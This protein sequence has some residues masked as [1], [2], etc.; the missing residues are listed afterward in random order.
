MKLKTLMVKEVIACA[1][2]TN[3]EEAGRLMWDHDC[4]AIPVLDDEGH[5][6]GIV[7]DRDIAMSAVLNHKPLWDISA[8]EVI[9]SREVFTCHANDDIQAALAVMQS[10]HI[11][12]MP[13]VDGDGRLL[14]LLSID[15]IVA[16]SAQPKGKRPPPVTFEETIT[17]LKA[18]SYHH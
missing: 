17:T 12:R 7:T 5:P 2:H 9:G 11:R 6:V 1:P 13:V 8:G 3:L 15:D 4:G 14:G 18:V 10:Q 16:R